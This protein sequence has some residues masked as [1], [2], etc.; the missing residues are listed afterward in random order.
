MEDPIAAPPQRSAASEPRR[1]RASRVSVSIVSAPVPIVAPALLGTAFLAAIGS[2]VL[3]VNRIDEQERV[4]SLR[5]ERVEQRIARLEAGISFDARR[6]ELLNGMRAAIARVNPEIDPRRAAHFAKLAL[7]ASERYPTVPPLLL[8]AVGVVE[9]GFRSDAVSSVGAR[10]LYQ[11]WPS[12]GRRLARSL[13]WEFTEDMLH[14]PR[15]NTEMA[16]LYL[17]MLFAAYNDPSLVLAEYNGGARNAGLFRARHSAVAEETRQYVPR[18]LAAYRR[19]Q[20]ELEEGPTLMTRSLYR[21]PR[22]RGKTL[23]PRAIARPEPSSLA[24]VTADE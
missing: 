12:T 2:I 18:V 22:R 19:L 24:I 10:G 3:L 23:P 20:T 9:S 15:V 17:D 16:A 6:Q 14:D 8:I 1:S 4:E 21:D 11:I 5:L 7:E 13:G